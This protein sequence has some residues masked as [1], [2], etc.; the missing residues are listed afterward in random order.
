[1]LELNLDTF[2]QSKKEYIE[3]VIEICKI[4]RAHV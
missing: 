4:G 2:M 3:S 1:M